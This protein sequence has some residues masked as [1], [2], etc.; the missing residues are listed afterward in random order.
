MI[1]SV[2]EIA[3][4]AGT[5]I[6]K[7]YRN[8][9]CHVEE[10]HDGSPVTEADLLSD[11]IITRRLKIISPYPVRTEESSWGSGDPVRGGEEYWLV[12]PLDGTRDFLAENDEFTINIALMKE[13]R[14]VMGVVYAPALQVMYWASCGK[15][16]FKN[17]EPIYNRSE[18]AE[19]IGIDSRFHSTELTL[20]FFQ[21]NGIRIVRRAGAGL[22]ICRLAEG[23]VDIYPRFNETKK[24]DTAAC[25]II[26]KEAGCNL[27]DVTTMRELAYDTAGIANNYFVACRNNLE[28]IV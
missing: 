10:K 28:F 26:A 6:L 1:A 8:R 15:G 20:Q 19:L 4:E 14:P 17:N 9:S 2:L 16:A 25:H 12:D 18:R 7:I 27:I 3:K 21:K 23:E 13:N 11:S 5:E 22:K 24:W